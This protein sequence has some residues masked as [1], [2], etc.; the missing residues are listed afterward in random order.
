[1][2][3]LIPSLGYYQRATGAEFAFQVVIDLPFV[4]RNCFEVKDPIIVPAKT[5]L[6]QLI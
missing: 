6:S 3:F 2:L 5:F 4:N 1:M